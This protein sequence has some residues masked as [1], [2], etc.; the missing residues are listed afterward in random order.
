MRD[1]RPG[2]V[3]APLPRRYSVDHPGYSEGMRRHRAAVDRNEPSYR[4][5]VSGLTVFTARFLSE[6]GYC[7]ESGCR[8]C[9]YEVPLHG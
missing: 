1:L 7:C 5:P 3:D 2:Y 8:H 4:D 6:R 9:P